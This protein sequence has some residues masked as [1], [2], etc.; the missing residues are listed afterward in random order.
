MKL[1]KLYLNNYG[2]LYGENTYHLEDKGG[3][4]SVV[5]DNGRGKST[6]LGSIP[7]ILYGEGKF[8]TLIDL[9]NTKAVQ[10]SQESTCD[11]A[12][13]FSVSDGEIFRVERSINQRGKM[14]SKI[15]LNDKLLTRKSEEVDAKVI[16]LL[17]YTYRDLDY[18][19]YSSQKNAAKFFN[20]KKNSDKKDF[21]YDMFNVNSESI[22]DHIKTKLSKFD[23]VK[24]KVQSRYSVISSIIKS[25]EDEVIKLKSISL[26]IDSLK[27]DREKISLKIDEFKSEKLSIENF[28]NSNKD[29]VEKYEKVSKS[30]SDCKKNQESLID[31]LSK[32]DSNIPKLKLRIDEF[33]VKLSEFINTSKVKFD[34]QKY[35]LAVKFIGDLDKKISSYQTSKNEIESKISSISSDIKLYSQKELEYSESINKNECPVCKSK[36]VGSEHIKS[37]LDLIKEKLSNLNKSLTSEKEKFSD[38]ATNIEKDSLILQKANEKFKLLENDKTLHENSIRV[39]SEKATIIKGLKSSNKLLKKENDLKASVDSSLKSNKDLLDNLQKELES[40][41]VVDITSS[42]ENLNSI[43]IKIKNLEEELDSL[44]KKE[45]EIKIAKAKINDIGAE[46]LKYESRKKKYSDLILQ[47]DKRI[48]WIKEFRTICQ[49]TF[50]DYTTISISSVVNLTNK[51]LEDINSGLEINI[52]V[53]KDFICNIYRDGHP[54]PFSLISGGLEVLLGICFRLG[55]WR[56]ISNKKKSPVSFL[57][58][59]EV[60]GELSPSNAQTLYNHISGLKKYFSYIFITSHTDHVWQSDHTLSV[61]G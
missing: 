54:V 43:K 44:D 3:I 33:Q 25:K 11:A 5:G 30:I 4:I 57:I 41:K 16:E 26:D 45:T 9:L 42:T 38:L 32:I 28:I 35:E 60:F 49:S 8:D 55:V 2:P 22:L 6:L 15:Y 58:L 48:L 1:L 18:T 27:L 52:S 40:L 13:D 36:G 20:I 7:F 51:F 23:K 37:E 14:T 61:S 17:K 21:L 50:N 12:L 39:R 56:F 34:N 10:E 53:E 24:D 31:N 47:L 59:D 19:L 46:I 29:N